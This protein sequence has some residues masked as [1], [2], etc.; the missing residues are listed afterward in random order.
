M[1]LS[2]LLSSKHES[3]SNV[4][5]FFPLVG[6]YRNWIVQHKW[7]ASKTC[8]VSCCHCVFYLHATEWKYYMLFIHI[9][10]N[11]H[12]CCHEYSW[13]HFLV[14]TGLDFCWMYACRFVESWKIYLFNILDTAKWFYNTVPNYSLTSRGIVS[15]LPH[16]CK[17]LPLSILLMLDILVEWISTSDISLQLYVAHHWLEMKLSIISCILLAFTYIFFCDM[18]AEVS[19]FFFFN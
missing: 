4:F 1:L 17:T 19:H 18:T 3:I 6:L 11:R 5:Q 2:I 15:L 10:V 16:H 13:I 9:T 14:H 12:L 8:E 7:L